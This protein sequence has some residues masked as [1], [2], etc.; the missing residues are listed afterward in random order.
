MKN[1]MIG[2]RDKFQVLFRLRKTINRTYAAKVATRI[3]ITPNPVSGTTKKEIAS[4]IPEEKRI[5]SSK[6]RRMAAVRDGIKSSTIAIF[7][8]ISYL[9]CHLVTYSSL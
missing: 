3:P 9:I 4:A 1:S 6:K 2:A 7:S 5:D 8:Y